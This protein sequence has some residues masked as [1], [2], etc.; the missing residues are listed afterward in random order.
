M[1]F[2]ALGWN[3]VGIAQVVTLIP[4]KFIGSFK[5]LARMSLTKGFPIIKLQEKGY[6]KSKQMCKS[7]GMWGESS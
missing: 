2:N 4:T 7:Q 1:S 3:L 5:W 6:Y